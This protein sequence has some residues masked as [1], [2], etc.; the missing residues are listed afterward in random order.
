M[1]HPSD[2]V[3]EVATPRDAALLENLLEL[4][5]HDLSAAFPSIELG[6][7]GRFGY[8][9]LPL[10]WSE[11]D[12]RF[13]FLIRYDTRI[14]GF[15][16]VT[17]GSPASDDPD[18]FDVAEF[19]I[20]RRYRRSGVGRQA[21][22]LVWDHLGGR[23]IVRVS[24]E[25]AGALPFWRGIIADYT[26]GGAVE[27]ERPGNADCWHLFSFVSRPRPTL[28]GALAIRPPAHHI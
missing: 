23:W 11:P 22:F 4:Y 9:K 3:L 25:V 27:S 15:V 17:R 12:R 24:A 21:A 10:Y 13:P 19:F 26:G 2:V 16:L 7:Q 1:S 28:P 8:P 5:I 14:V 6:A 18:V 20:I